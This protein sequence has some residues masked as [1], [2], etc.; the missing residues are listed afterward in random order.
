MIGISIILW[1]TISSLVLLLRHETNCIFINWHIVPMYTIFREFSYNITCWPKSTRR[2]TCT[3]PAA[4]IPVLL[5]V[6]FSKCAKKRHWSTNIDKK[7]LKNLGDLSTSIPPF[8][9]LEG[10]IPLS[11]YF[12]AL[13]ATL[14]LLLQ[15]LPVLYRL[16]NKK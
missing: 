10:T 16:L 5:T 13:I 8:K 3:S 15:P 4:S 9:I 2:C 1:P 14:L 6:L 11:P 7:E 12:A